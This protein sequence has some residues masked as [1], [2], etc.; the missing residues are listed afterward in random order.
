VPWLCEAIKQNDQQKCEQLWLCIF[1]NS[2]TGF[3]GRSTDDKDEHFVSFCTH[4]KPTIKNVTTNKKK[5]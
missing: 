2:D 5:V 4:F 3:G 1:E